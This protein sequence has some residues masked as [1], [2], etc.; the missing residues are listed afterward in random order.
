MCFCHISCTSCL[1]RSW[2]YVMPTSYTTFN[3]TTTQQCSVLMSAP[4]ISYEFVEGIK[5]DIIASL[6][7]QANPPASAQVVAQPVRCDAA[8]D[9]AIRL[10]FHG[11]RE[12]N[13]ERICANGLDRPMVHIG[14]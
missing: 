3:M 4:A 9:K 2:P 8:G 11:T 7:G 6:S 1:S 14:A 13:I 10:V 5:A 12:E